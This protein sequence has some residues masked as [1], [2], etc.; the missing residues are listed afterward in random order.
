M[1]FLHSFY[2]LLVGYFSM[3]SALRPA[4]LIR[5]LRSFASLFWRQLAPPILS[6]FAGQFLQLPSHLE[7]QRFR[8]GRIPFP[9]FFRVV[10]H[11]LRQKLRGRDIKL[12]RISSKLFVERFRQIEPGCRDRYLGRFCGAAFFWHLIGLSLHSWNRSG[13]FTPTAVSPICCTDK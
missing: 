7:A 5:F 8:G 12:L 10:C 2:R 1:L 9:Q 6:A 11:A 3:L 4:S 13:F